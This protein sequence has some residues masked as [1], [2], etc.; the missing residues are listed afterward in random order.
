M[1]VDF[2]IVGTQKGG[3]SALAK[4][5][6]QHPNIFI[7]EQKELHF[8]DNEKIFKESSVD[9]EQYHK[10]FRTNKQQTLF[11]EATP[12]Y[13]YWKAAAKRIYDYNPDIKLIFILRNPVDRAYSHYQMQVSRNKERLS[14]HSALFFEPI[15]QLLSKTKQNR[16]YSYA[17][18]GFYSKSI[19]RMKRFFPKE[20]MLFLRTD[21]LFIHH[22]ETL[23][24]VFKFL[25][26]PNHDKIEQKV[27][28]ANEYP[29]IKPG[30]KKYLLK[31]FNKEFA[32]LEQELLWD[33]TSWKSSGNFKK[34]TT[35][36]HTDYTNSR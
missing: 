20:Q 30:D 6:A 4:F 2:L 8:F 14:F 15:R 19:K 3:T 9:Y 13:M 35:F 28:F 22:K 26:L 31:K 25:G 16:G 5:M 21:D 34:N 29:S 24:K 12:V 33:L 32:K 27:I 7:P 18:R 36:T 23:S 11:G 17:D 1:K 10:Y